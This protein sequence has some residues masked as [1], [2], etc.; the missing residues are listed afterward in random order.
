MAS[1]SLLRTVAAMT[2]H[3]QARV[4]VAGGGIAALEFALA[5]REAAGDRVDLT[6]VAPDR[7]LL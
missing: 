7:D 1:R 2:R 5:L 6:L 3:P 4:V